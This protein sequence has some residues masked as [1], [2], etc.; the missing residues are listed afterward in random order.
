MAQIFKNTYFIEHLSISD[1]DVNKLVAR[2]KRINVLY[3]NDANRFATRLI[4]N[5]LDLKPTLNH[6]AK[7]ASLAKWLSVFIGIFDFPPVTS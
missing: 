7:L 3:L 6:L 2:N 5:H 1:S 4:Q